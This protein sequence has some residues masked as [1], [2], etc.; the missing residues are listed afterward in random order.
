MATS[1][2]V[3]RLAPIATT[4][5]P[6]SAHL[7]PVKPQSLLRR[8]MPWQASTTLRSPA[9]HP[10]D[11]NGTR[12][13]DKTAPRPRAV[14]G[15]SRRLGVR[16][17]I[18]M[19]FVC[20]CQL[21]FGLAALSHMRALEA[22]NQRLYRE[23]LQQAA[24]AERAGGD[25]ARLRNG[26][27][28]LFVASSGPE[29]DAARQLI[30]ASVD[31]IAH[32]LAKANG[33]PAV[34]RRAQQSLTQARRQVDEFVALMVKQSFD[35]V[36]FDSAVSV[37]GHFV[38]TALDGLG[39]AIAALRRSQ[40]AATEARAARAATVRARTLGALALLFAATLC[41]SLL[42][43]FYVGRTLR[44][45][46]GGEPREAAQLAARIAGGDLAAST[47]SRADSASVFG[48]IARMRESLVHLVA[49]VRTGADSIAL[50]SRQIAD[51]NEAL[52][53]RTR[54]Q[55]ASIA[56]TAANAS[57]LSGAVEHNAAHARQASELAREAAAV[58]D[59]GARQTE[60]VVATMRRLANES[61]RMG[62]IVA[63]IDGIAFQTNLLALN[64]AVEAARAGTQGRG[65][66][67]VAGEVRELARRSAEAA[68]DVKARIDGSLAGV[69]TSE[70]A[71]EA[72]GTT[73][74]DARAA[75]ERVA[76]LLAEIEQASESQRVGIARIDQAVGDIDAITRD[77]AA[78]VLAAHAA[79]DA[80]AE[81]TR[82]LQQAVSVFR[83]ERHAT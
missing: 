44:R 74:A 9:S 82:A 53:T 31:S 39:E 29:R 17:G 15:R 27:L 55:A 54:A 67:V 52:A 11:R 69:Q 32:A 23:D 75:S 59:S 13:D 5:P 24:A 3:G 30:A 57:R 70:R 36:M 51:D 61:R 21:G 62:E 41:A 33:D 18:G 37:N 65:F 6:M 25:V 66:A 68:R 50:A 34:A 46:L 73:M 43:W 7:S 64:A 58:C 80:L 35:P 22:D 81:R 77:N 71:A 26:K 8:F 79:S 76:A 45:E 49:D 47:G 78:R 16:V 28:A 83:L 38:D 60:A 12:S 72:A 56:E 48:A 4:P 1:Q 20:L 40:D 63:V 19:L 2:S 14:L 10:A 42:V